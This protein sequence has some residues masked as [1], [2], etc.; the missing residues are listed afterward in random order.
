MA[1]TNN[2]SDYLTDIANAIRNKKGTTAKIPAQNFSS[3][4]AS[5]SSG[6]ITPSGSISITSNG[7]YDVTTKATAVVSVPTPTPT[8]Y[9]GTYRSSSDTS[10]FR[11]TLG[12]SGCKYFAIFASTTPDINHTDCMSW[13]GVTNMSCWSRYRGSYSTGYGNDAS[14]IEIDG[15]QIYVEIQQA[16]LSLAG[17]VTYQWLAK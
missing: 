1:K 12:F 7:T 11:I 2:L 15:D 5:I 8:G 6:G 10:A 9:G 4:I 14:T 3:E 17:G 16:N 13:D